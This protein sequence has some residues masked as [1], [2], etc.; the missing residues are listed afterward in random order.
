MQTNGWD[1]GWIGK[2]NKTPQRIQPTHVNTEDKKNGTAL[3]E[4]GMWNNFYDLKVLLKTNS[5][6]NSTF[7]HI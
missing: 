4:A 5:I 6:N 2:R 7:F 3:E 1:R